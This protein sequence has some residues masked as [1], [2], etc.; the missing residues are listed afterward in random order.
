MK[1]IDLVQFGQDHHLAENWTLAG[2]DS[3]SYSYLLEELSAKLPLKDP[4]K[5]HEFILSGESAIWDDQ[6]TLH[7]FLTGNQL[8][9][10]HWKPILLKNTLSKDKHLELKNYVRLLLNRSEILDSCDIFK[11]QTILNPP[12]LKEMHVSLTDL[13]CEKLGR[14]VAP[15]Y[16]FLS[17]YGEK[18]YC[19][20]HRDRSTCQWTLDLCIDQDRPWPIFVEEHELLM[21][22]NDSIIYSGT[23]QLHWR[24]KIHPQ[25]F[26][27]LV[28]FHFLETK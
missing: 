23:D 4:Q 7:Q 3:L 28:F 2:L 26:C 24:D 22:A 12:Y 9:R 13:V 14:K 27:H 25:G 18:G 17:L 6:Q 20:P 16:S 15:T 8:Q 10:K 21:E 19:P 1:N 11:R 5:V